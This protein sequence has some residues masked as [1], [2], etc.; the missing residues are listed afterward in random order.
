MSKWELLDEIY[1]RFGLAPDEAELKRTTQL[2]I[3]GGFVQV[4]SDES[5]SRMSVNARGLE[6]LSELERLLG[7]V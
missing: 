7:V 3:N 2:L 1:G 6:L 4:V 5:Q